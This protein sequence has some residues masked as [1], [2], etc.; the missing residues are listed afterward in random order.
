MRLSEFFDFLT[1]GELSNLKVGGKDVGGIYPQHSEEVASYVKQGLTDLHTRFQLRFNEVI[2]DQYDHI[3]MYHLTRNYA[4]SNSDSTETYKY[5]SDSV[6]NPFTED[7]ISIEEIFDED[8]VELYINNEVQQASVFT[9][10]FNILQIPEPV[11]ENSVSI[12]YKANHK[13]IDLNIKKPSEIDLNIPPS[14]IRPL[15]LYVASL[16]HAAVGSPEGSQIALSKMQEYTAAVID[17]QLLGIVPRK[18][19]TNDKIWR[20]GWV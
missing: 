15:A 6:D 18:Q 19:W 7:I 2:L 5:I 17:V 20:N 10:Q 14:L 8:G 1:Y 9:P 16:A 4:Q 12:L 3:T 13:E 11:T